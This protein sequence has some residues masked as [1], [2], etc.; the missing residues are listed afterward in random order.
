M[1]TSSP[2][3]RRQD[4]AA[5]GELLVVDR[6]S[7][8]VQDG[9]RT[10]VRD[11]SLSLYKKGYLEKLDGKPGMQNFAPTATVHEPSVRPASRFA[12]TRSPACATASFRSV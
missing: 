3:E 1:V 12:R 10:A 11:V 4:P 9:A 2:A 5:G 6:L 8:S 7:I